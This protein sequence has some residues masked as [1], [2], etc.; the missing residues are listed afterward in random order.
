MG[1]KHTGADIVCRWGPRWRWVARATVW[2]CVAF[3]GRAWPL[4]VTQAAAP[5][6]SFGRGRPYLGVAARAAPA[7]KMMRLGRPRRAT[8]AGRPAA[9]PPGKQ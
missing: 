7:E 1:P 6:P 9:R 3:G 5:S 4:H 8:P 2:A